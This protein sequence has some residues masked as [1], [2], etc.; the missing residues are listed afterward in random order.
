MDELKI[1]KNAFEK[2]DDALDDWALSNGSEKEGIWYISGIVDMVKEL[3][4]G[5]KKDE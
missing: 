3:L 5:I 1:L 4:K 2:I